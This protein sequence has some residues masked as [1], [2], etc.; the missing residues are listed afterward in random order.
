MSGCMRARDDDGDAARALTLFRVECLW[1]LLIRLYKTTPNSRC[2]FTSVQFFLTPFS[3][4]RA[5]RGGT[6]VLDQ[7]GV[8]L[9]EIVLVFPWSMASSEGN[10]TPLKHEG[11]PSYSHALP[12]CSCSNFRDGPR[13]HARAPI[14]RRKRLPCHFCP[15]PYHYSC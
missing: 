5:Q 12:P 13:G 15:W 14:D 9:L 3:L 8:Y 4:H 11:K 7:A 10:A 1:K 2:A 6:V